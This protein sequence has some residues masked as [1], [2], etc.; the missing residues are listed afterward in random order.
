[1][2]VQERM[3]REMNLNNILMASSEASM[4]VSVASSPFAAMLEED[5][6]IR[7]Y[8]Y[9]LDELKR[10]IYD[11]G[12]ILDRSANIKDFQRFRDLIRALTDKL[13]KDA[14]RVREVSVFNRS[15][16]MYSSRQYK[17]VAKINE[18]LDS[19]Y[20]LIMKEQK[21]HIAIANKVM[22]LKG[23]VLDLMS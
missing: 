18:E 7:K 1:M 12:N 13:I 9:E 23:L 15:R 2:R 17:V 3:N 21:N 14:Y 5:K 10:Q 20:T 8:S 22:R 19:L 4:K 16:S 6:E 11:A